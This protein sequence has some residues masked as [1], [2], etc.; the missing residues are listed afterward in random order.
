MLRLTVEGGG[1]SGFTY[2]FDLDTAS[3]PDD[4]CAQHAGW[5]ACK[6][7]AHVFAKLSKDVLVRRHVVLGAD[8]LSLVLAK[9][10]HA[11]SSNTGLR[12][13]VV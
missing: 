2:L 12:P 1:C 3:A 5:V 6:D 11:G 4:R 8:C 10:D 9:D 13:C 7:S